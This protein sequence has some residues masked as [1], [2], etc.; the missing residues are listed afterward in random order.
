M[1]DFYGSFIARIP[2]DKSSFLGND[3]ECE[4]FAS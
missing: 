1:N 4:I 3:P 2:P